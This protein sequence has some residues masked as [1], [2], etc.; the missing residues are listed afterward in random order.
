MIATMQS[1][2]SITKLDGKVKKVVKSVDVE[3]AIELFNEQVKILKE[4]IFVKR[5]Q[6]KHDNRLKE[7]LKKNEFIIHID[8]SKNYKDKEQDE[9]QSAYFRH[10]LFSIFTACCYTRVIEGAPLNKNFTVTSEAINYSRIAAFSCNNLII[11]SLQKKFPSQFN[12]YPVL[13]ME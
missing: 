9:I 6:N 4:H 10:N 13:Y 5:T 1:I 11:D 3:E 2:R 7:N 12:N 8:Y